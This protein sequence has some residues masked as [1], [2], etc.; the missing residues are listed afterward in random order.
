MD[1][2]ELLT[3]RRK[4]VRS[5]FVEEEQNASG[6]TIDCLDVDLLQ[7]ILSNLDQEQR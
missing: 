2:V 7:R 4:K 6:T 5:Q 3:G 1:P